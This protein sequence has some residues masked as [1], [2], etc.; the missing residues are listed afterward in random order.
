MLA[1]SDKCDHAHNKE[2]LMACS[3]G[4]R[5]GIVRCVTWRGLD[6]S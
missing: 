3:N 2:G 4:V 6:S 5:D 1:G